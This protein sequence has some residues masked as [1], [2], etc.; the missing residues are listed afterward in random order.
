MNLADVYDITRL[1][2]GNV[3]MWPFNEWALW[4]MATSFNY[5]IFYHDKARMK[6]TEMISKVLYYLHN[7]QLSYVYFKHGNNISF[8]NKLVTVNTACNHS[9]SVVKGSLYFACIIIEV[10]FIYIRLLSIDKEVTYS[11]FILNKY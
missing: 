2:A 6:E 11:Y 4:W 9:T 7:R 5:C 1:S 3:K 8:L 10:A